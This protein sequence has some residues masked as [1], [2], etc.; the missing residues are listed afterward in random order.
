MIESTYQ[1]DAYCVDIMGLANIR[2][3]IQA[4]ES[5]ASNELVK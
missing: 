1:P 3:W 5:E 2:S 4:F